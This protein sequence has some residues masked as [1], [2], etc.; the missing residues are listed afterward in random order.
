M[1]ILDGNLGFGDDNAEVER[2]KNHYVKYA[3]RVR[4]AQV[5]FYM[6]MLLAF[7]NYFYH[8]CQ[9]S[10][11]AIS[12]QGL[13]TIIS[14][15]IYGGLGIVTN[16]HPKSSLSIGIIF[17]LAILLIFTTSIPLSAVPIVSLFYFGFGLFNAL[18]MDEL[19]KKLNLFNIENN[20]E[21]I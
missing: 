2:L 20:D 16:Y 10:E 12:K 6:L 9:D 7:F 1:D 3:K 19:E 14:A 18:K 11:Y 4:G 17:M 21:S 8:T 13:L 15:I 5:M